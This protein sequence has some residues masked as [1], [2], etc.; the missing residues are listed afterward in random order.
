MKIVFKALL[1]ILTLI[2][3][4]MKLFPVKERITFIS[5]QSNEKSEDML[6]LEREL[7]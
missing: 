4:V 2:Y 6:L 7:K 5:R 1:G 3:G